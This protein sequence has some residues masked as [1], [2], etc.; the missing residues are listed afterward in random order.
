MKPSPAISLVGSS[1][2]RASRAGRCVLAEG[3]RGHH[4]A[5][6]G[7]RGETT[8]AVGDDRVGR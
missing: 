6:R 5:V 7:E 3:G 1:L 4:G 2:S 8:R